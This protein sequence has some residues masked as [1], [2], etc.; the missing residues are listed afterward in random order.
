[1]GIVQGKYNYFSK[2]GR[3]SIT[4]LL[5]K[6]RLYLAA[7]EQ[8]VKHVCKRI[9]TTMLFEW[10]NEK[11]RLNLKKHGISFEEAATVFYDPLSTTF[12]DPDHSKVEHR[13]ITIGVSFQNRLLV[14]A[15]TERGNSIRVINARTATSHERKRHEG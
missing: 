15:H 2:T 9:D 12:D 10:D 14:V 3:I 6:D 8:P 5:H 7:C 1:V 11:A 4:T 13:L